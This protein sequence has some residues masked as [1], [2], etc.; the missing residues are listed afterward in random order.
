MD[1]TESL[2]VAYLY[3][4]DGA[5]VY[6][7]HLDRPRILIGSAE[8]NDVRVRDERMSPHHALLY[9]DK[10]HYQLT[11]ATDRSIIVNGKPV[12]RTRALFNGDVM[13]LAGTCITFIRPPTVSDTVVQLALCTGGDAPWFALLNKPLISVGHTRGDLLVPDDF[14]SD[15]HC[16]IENFCA[17]AHFILGADEERGTFVNGARVTKRQRLADR[18]VIRVGATDITVRFQRMRALPTADTL[19]PLDQLDRAARR[20]EEEHTDELRQ[21]ARRDER[22]ARRSVREILEA[23]DRDGDPDKMFELNDFE[24]DADDKPYYLPE[25]QRASRPSAMDAVMDEE[26]GA[27]NTMLIPTTTKGKVKKDRYYLPE[28]QQPER[29]SAPPRGEGEDT[30]TDLPTAKKRKK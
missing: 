22:G 18:D 16:I 30:R 29:R 10:G 24:Q 19:I 17:G 25:H 3:L 20:P 2:P 5:D 7:V 21:V 28:D 1:P 14:V 26:A 12:D 11:S 27:G 15:P 23:H 4:E 8:D 13:D 6:R 9:F